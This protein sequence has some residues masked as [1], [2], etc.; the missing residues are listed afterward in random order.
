MKTHAET[1]L[2]RPLSLAEK[3]RLVIEIV[4]SYV[5]TRRAL[6]GVDLRRAL[7]ELRPGGSLDAHQ[8]GREEMV[9][10]ARLGVVVRRVLSPIPVDS[11]CLMQSLVL[12]QLLARRDIPSRL[13]IGVR[14]GE[15]FGAHAWV[16]L[17][18]RPVLPTGGDEFARLVE[19]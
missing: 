1:V 7:A 16:E 9:E 4:R 13:V 17:E 12:T 6:G 18:G 11:R 5:R 15:V 8:L 10:A 2:P 19:L 14:P 3:A